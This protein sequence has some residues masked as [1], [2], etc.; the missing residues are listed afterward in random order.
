MGLWPLHS[1]RPVKVQMSNGVLFSPYG[2]CKPHTLVMEPLLPPARAEPPWWSLNFQWVDEPLM[3][4]AST[5]VPQRPHS[6]LVSANGLSGAL[7]RAGG[8][9]EAP[10]FPERPLSLGPAVSPDVHWCC[11]HSGRGSNGSA[12]SS[13]SRGRTMKVLLSPG[14]SSL[15]PAGGVDAP[16]GCDHLGRASSGSV[17]PSRARPLLTGVGAPQA[18][19]HLGMPAVWMFLGAVITWAGDCC[20]W[21]GGPFMGQAS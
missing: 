15:R 16:W 9:A 6:G 2:D 21:V 14:P 10:L 13:R 1:G 5:D 4:W 3:D 18:P 19:L 12:G 17:G 8:Q 20:G 7:T 11:H